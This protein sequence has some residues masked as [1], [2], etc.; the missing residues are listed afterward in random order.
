MKRSI[1]LPLLALALVLG[2]GL[3]WAGL[4]RGELRAPAS[5]GVQ[6]ESS[7]DAVVEPRNGAGAPWGVAEAAGAP[8]SV[9]AVGE[10]LRHWRAAVLGPSSGLAGPQDGSAAHGASA[11]PDPR[12]GAGGRPP[13]PATL[14]ARS[15][16]PGLDAPE[17]PAQVLEALAQL[18]YD[19]FRD[20]RFRPEAAFWGEADRFRLQLFHPGSIHTDQVR[21]HRI[22]AE[23][24]V[25][26][27]LDPDLFRY[28]AGGQLARRARGELAL[29]PAGFRIHTPFHEAGIW[30]EVAVFLGASYFRLLGRGHAYG[31]SGRGVAVHTTH[32]GREEFP[33]FR[34]FWLLDPAPGDAGVHFFARLDGQAVTGAFHFHLRPGLPTELEVEAHLFVH[35]A[36]EELGL[37]PL[38]SMFL[39]APGLGPALDDFRPRIHDSD[40]LVILEADGTRHWRPLASPGPTPQVVDAEGT[41]IRGFGLLQRTR[42]FAAYQD[43][44]ARYHDRPSFFVEFLEAD[45]WS[46]GDAAGR[47]EA[48]TARRDGPSGGGRTPGEGSV[49][50]L[51]LPADSEFHDNVVAFWAPRGGA[52]PGDVFRL[53]YR[54]LALDDVV[55]E[56][57]VAQDP[58]LAWV[59]D[60]RIGSAEL[61]GAAPSPRVRARRF[62]VDFAPPPGAG[63]ATRASL[64][65]LEVVYRAS[66]GRVS[67][68]RAELLPG[69]QGW[70][71]TFALDPERVLPDGRR[72]VD[73][74]T[75]EEARLGE[76]VPSELALFLRRDGRPVSEIWMH[77]WTPAEPGERV[78]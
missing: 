9:L 74:T 51:V 20:I 37:A 21:L 40:G 38:T 46:E 54:V 61:P 58:P 34:E 43:L 47:P 8:P 2:A 23:G 13:F 50:L 25:P 11:A 33:A 59:R 72:L 12:V 53:R 70:R 29:E 15:R 36:V 45:R 31:I 63:P 62:V 16:A 32:F 30:D 57:V 65:G 26:V 75:P 49:R 77:S 66:T 42:E 14:L 28:D 76:L 17:A 5:G 24:V 71:A 56:A 73:P 69:G 44:E 18:G 39:T 68:V 7:P 6:G 19:A 52:Q 78:P 64:E 3:A 48:R 1:L 67:D 60:T 10:E 22:T 41:G 55:E 27:V 4:P 35:E